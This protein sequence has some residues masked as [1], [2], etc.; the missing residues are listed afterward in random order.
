MVVKRNSAMTLTVGIPNLKRGTN[1]LDIEV[2]PQ[3]DVTVS[4][5]IEFF[6]DALGGAGMTPSTSMMLTGSPG[7]GKTTLCLQLAESITKTGNICLFNTGE[8][9]LYQVRKHTR[10][11]KVA[12]GFVPGQDV[13]VDDVLAHA[14]DLRKKNSNKRLFLL[15]DSLQ[16]LDDGFYNNGVTNSMTPVRCIEKITDYC[17][18]HYAIAIC[19]GQ[20]NKNGDFAGKNILLHAVDVRAHLGF[21]EDKKSETFG[22]RIFNVTKNRWGCSGKKYILGMRDDGLYEKGTISYE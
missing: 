2:P 9:S 20:V 15:F 22:E 1:I 14:D 8:E 3:L 18:K 6:D 7:A 13:L 16:T 10:R 19:I 21:D 5:G 12:N 11:L 4:T 17:K